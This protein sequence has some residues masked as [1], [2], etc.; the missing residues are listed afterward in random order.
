MPLHIL[1]VDDERLSRSY[2][3]DLVRE[4]EPDATVSLAASGEEALEI[5][6]AG[7][8]DLLFLDIRMP[9][10][11][12]FTLLTR[13]PHRNFELV[14]ITA[15]SEH[16]I[17]AIKEGAIDYLLKP[18]RKSDFKE[19]LARVTQR[20]KATLE[21]QQQAARTEDPLAQKLSLNH[22]QGMH[23]IALRDISYLKADN[24]Y[25]TLFLRDGRKITTSRA[26]L[27]FEESLPQPWF[28]RIH[29]S[30][31]INVAELK[32]FSSKD[33]DVAVMNNGDRLYISRY[34]LPQFL[35]IIRE[36]T[37]GLQL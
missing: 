9:G 7:D 14:F 31:I 2:L 24:S 16:A 10:M 30:Y 4:F 36:M 12:G 11:D 28:F 6:E 37:G 35:N 23:V 20:R 5:I 21:L 8:I 15:H 18:V 27:R 25:T 17:Q 1:I 33:G 3:H 32:A 13:M 29:K 22:Q 19:M 26:M 34:R